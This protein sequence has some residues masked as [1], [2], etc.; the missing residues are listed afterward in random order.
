MNLDTGGRLEEVRRISTPLRVTD[1]GDASRLTRE[2]RVLLDLLTTILLAPAILAAVFFGLFT[3]YFAQM[4]LVAVV[5]PSAF[6]A[7][8]ARM[9]AYAAEV[10]VFTGILPV[11]VGGVVLTLTLFALAAAARRPR[12]WAL[13]LFE[14]LAALTVRY[15]WTMPVDELSW[16]MTAIRSLFTYGVGATALLGGLWMGAGV[17]QT[18]RTS[19][20]A[21]ML[22]WPRFSIPLYAARYGL[23]S[24]RFLGAL[25]RNGIVFAGLSAIAAAAFLLYL[26][27]IGSVAEV[28]LL[29]YTNVDPQLQWPHYLYAMNV[30][31][32]TGVGIISL[33]TAV[34]R[35]GVRWISLATALLALGAAIELSLHYWNDIVVMHDGTGPWFETIDTSAYSIAEWELE[36]LLTIALVLTFRSFIASAIQRA[37]RDMHATSARTARELSERRPEP[38]ILF[39][40]SFMDDEQMVPSADAVFMHALGAVRE[41]VRLEEIVAGVMFARGPLVALANPLVDAVPIGAARDVAADDNWQDRVSEYLHAS[42]AIVCFLGKTDN[43]RWEIDRIIEGGR[44]DAMLLVLPPTYPDDRTLFEH[45]PRLAA[46]MGLTSEEQ[47]REALADVMVIFHD[48]ERG[49]FLAIRSE[50]ADS[51]AYREAITIGAAI[52]AHNHDM[53]AAA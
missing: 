51:W 42:Q 46:L 9:I 36:A 24:L 33:V 14:A 18:R 8:L 49:E 6:P 11:A 41:T 3:I 38:P 50:Y 30:L 40:R 44:L 12:V 39:L 5:D 4:R 32:W 16:T 35:R 45:A 52:V 53:Q 47:E 17:W 31:T 1:L 23:G 2:G 10:P 27:A 43:F 19:E 7:M 34:R 48:A 20:G 15:V 28:L 21:A 13:L 26:I 29:R 37:I 22:R 25:L